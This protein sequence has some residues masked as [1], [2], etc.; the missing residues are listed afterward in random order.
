VREQ[1]AKLAR[2]AAGGDPAAR[3]EL[4]RRYGPVSFR[5][6]RSLGLSDH[7]AEDI[8]QDVMV[9]LLGAIGRYDPKKAAIGTLVYR[10]TV[11]A[12]HDFRAK[13]QHR[14][15]GASTTVIRAVPSPRT[16][17]EAEKLEFGEM[18]A[19]IVNQVRTLPARQ[20]QVCVLH[21]LEGMSI[22]DTAAALEI[23]PTNVRV[24]LTHARRALRER[25][26][27]LLEG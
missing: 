23:T 9:K 16:R 6:A 1:D 15:T 2:R 12:V 4:V 8:A 26:A 18:R 17:A 20:R 19:L 25:L 27:H 7:D 13:P 22:A 14:E 3:E 21:D 11:N 10:I 24:H 5:C